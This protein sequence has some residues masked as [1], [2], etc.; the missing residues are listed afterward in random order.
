MRCVTL[1]LLISPIF[2]LAAGPGLNA[3]AAGEEDRQSKIEWRMPTPQLATV[4]EHLQ[5]SGKQTFEQDPNHLGTPL[6]VVLAGLAYLPSIVESV[7]SV[8]RQVVYGGVIIDVCG[9]KL[10]IRNDRAIPGEVIVVRCGPSVVLY[11]SADVKP[12]DLLKVLL[13]GKSLNG[14]AGK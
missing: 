5:F 14:A 12:E 3:Q 6:F 8:Y 7:V 1:L 13:Q 11:R 4:N 9:D 10:E 2:A